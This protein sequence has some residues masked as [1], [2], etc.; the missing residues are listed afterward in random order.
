MSSEFVPQSD[1]DR[2]LAHLKAVVVSKY[3]E[4]DGILAVTVLQRSLVAY[5]EITLMSTWASGEHLANF[6]A[7][8]PAVDP[9]QAGFVSIQRDQPRVHQLV[10]DISRAVTDQS[11]ERTS[12]KGNVG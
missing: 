12:Q 9:I 5:D 7:S 10:M 4:A 6:M 3:L 8:N 11:Q 1:I 2:Y